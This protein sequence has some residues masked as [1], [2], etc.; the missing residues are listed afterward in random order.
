MFNYISELESYTI[1][2]AETVTIEVEGHDLESLLF[3]FMDEMLMAFCIDKMVCKQVK[4]T[5][6]DLENFKIKAQGYV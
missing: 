4:I 6:F 1:D 3:N 5:E 2:P